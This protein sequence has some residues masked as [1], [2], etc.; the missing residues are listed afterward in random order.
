MNVFT[1]PSTFTWGMDSFFDVG[2]GGRLDTAGAGGVVGST[3]NFTYSVGVWNQVVVII[4]LDTH[5]A[6]YWIG[7]QPSNFTQ[8]AAWDWTQGGSKPNQLA[9]NDFFGAAATDEM[10]VDNFYFDDEMPAVVPVELSSFTASVNPQGQAILNWIT[11]S[12]IN[13]RGFE[14]QR[15]AVEGQ[16]STIG[17]VQGYGTTTEEQSY[18][19]ADNNVNPGTYQYRLKQIDFDGRFEYSEAIELDV[20]PPLA[21]G[22]E[23]NYPNPFNPST[24]IKYSIAEAGYVKLAIYN[25]I[26]EQVSVLVDGQQNAGFFEVNFNAS[27]LPS[28]T[29]LY[30]LDGPGFTTAKKMLLMK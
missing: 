9:V 25:A 11:A 27:N 24:K 7:T 10:Y 6:E 22:L 17:F 20:T 26:G 21:F 5:V 15:R 8:I 2:G 13:N 19:Y 14:I 28:G 30:K 1:R 3:V 12:E 4:D 18:T 29:Y 23:Q 16:F